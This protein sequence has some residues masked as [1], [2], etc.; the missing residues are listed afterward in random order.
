MLN[1]LAAFGVKA[2]QARDTS[3][4]GSDREKFQTGIEVDIKDPFA[5]TDKPYEEITQKHL[6]KVLS[7]QVVMD[8]HD[9]YEEKEKLILFLIDGRTPIYSLSTGSKF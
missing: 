6:D 5:L 7:A 1:Q 8:T 2:K 9:D 4:L 3:G